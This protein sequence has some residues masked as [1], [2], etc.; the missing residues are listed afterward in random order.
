MILDMKHSKQIR[1]NKVVPWVLLICSLIG[2]VASL[3]LSMDRINLA[4]DP[5][6]TL[7]CDINPLLSCG[8]VMST[9]ESE[10]FG[11]PNSLLGVIGFSGLAVVGVVL[12]AG[13]TLQ[14]WFWLCLGAGT[15][16]ALVFVI[17]LF[18]Q[19]VYDIGVLCPYCVAVWIATIPAFWYTMLYLF[20]MKFLQL[21]SRFDGLIDWSKRHHVDVLGAVFLLMFGLVL[22]QFWDII[23]ILY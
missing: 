14:R 22:V 18:Y 6:A 3:G 4:E 19:T 20:D 12:L 11:V 9:A 10:V 13:A 1:L 16:S 15:V 5:N 2:L 23:Q 21:P 8:S 7:A 17:W